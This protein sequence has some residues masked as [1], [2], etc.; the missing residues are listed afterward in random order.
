MG[1]FGKVICFNAS[2]APSDSEEIAHM[3]ME[4]YTIGKFIFPI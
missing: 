2:F 4:I 1:Q 3:Y